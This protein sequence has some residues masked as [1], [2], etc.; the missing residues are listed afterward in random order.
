L[1][2]LP[3]FAP[4]PAGAR[5]LDAGCG[6]GHGLQALRRAYP[7]AQLYGIE[8]S[9]A[10]RLLC[11]LR[12][13]WARISR[14]DIWLADWSGYHMVYL[15]QRPESMPKAVAKAARELRPGAVL[16]SLDFEAAQLVPKASYSARDG[17]MV[18]IYKMPFLRG[19]VLKIQLH[20]RTARKIQLYLL[21]HPHSELKLRIHL[22]QIL[23]RHRMQLYLRIVQPV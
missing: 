13:P 5:V 22:L 20:N 9:A 4:L 23:Q 17:K 1:Y 11:A 2:Q 3:S 18:W 16:V 14:G 12:L 19:I 15:F 6:L 7:Q 10:L 21:F 8:W